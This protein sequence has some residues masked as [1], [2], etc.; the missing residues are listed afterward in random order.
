MK[1]LILYLALFPFLSYSQIISPCSSSDTVFCA[2]HAN[3]YTYNRTRGLWFQAK[4]SFK[5]ISVK[6]GDG[7]HQG[8]LATNQSIEIIQ[9]INAPLISGFTNPHTVLFS[10]INTPW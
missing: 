1:K 3:D 2:P 6:A 5:I 4:S 8:V 10:T 9:F 7:N